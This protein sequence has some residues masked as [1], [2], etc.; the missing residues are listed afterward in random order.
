MWGSNVDEDVPLLLSVDSELG[1]LLQHAAR[2]AGEMS[3]A[4]SSLPF[5]TDISWVSTWRGPGT[6]QESSRYHSR[7][8]YFL[9]LLDWC[10]SPQEAIQ[11]TTPLRLR[12]GTRSG[13]GTPDL[14]PVWTTP[15]PNP[16]WSKPPIQITTNGR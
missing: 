2:P 10:T 4:T 3:A 12:V 7:T 13:R 1:S 14:D 8:L 15:R 9:S 5:W 11:R 6:L 16:V